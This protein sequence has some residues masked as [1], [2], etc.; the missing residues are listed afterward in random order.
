MQIYIYRSIYLYLY[1]YIYIYI[2]AAHLISGCILDTASVRGRIS[3][4]IFR[5]S[6]SPPPPLPIAAMR[7]RRHHK[8]KS[9]DRGGVGSRSRKPP[10]VYDLALNRRHASIPI[11]LIMN[12]PRY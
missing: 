4:R 11:I 12:N 8:S 6:A 7:C 3:S 2:N 1:L 9:C 5:P 10:A